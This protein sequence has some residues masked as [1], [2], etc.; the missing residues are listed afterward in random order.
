MS[1]ETALEGAFEARVGQLVRRIAGP[2]PDAPMDPSAMLDRAEA[3]VAKIDLWGQRGVTGVSTED[4]A[5]MALVIAL[6]GAIPALRAR[7]T[8]SYPTKQ[9]AKA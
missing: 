9:G 8:V 5:A 6:S 3:A 7:L 2:A 4:I 1:F